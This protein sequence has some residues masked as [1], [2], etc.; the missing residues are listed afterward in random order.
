MVAARFFDNCDQLERRA[1]IEKRIS[2]TSINGLLVHRY[3]RQLV[4]PNGSDA[5]KGIALID[6][7]SCERIAWQRPAEVSCQRKQKRANGKNAA[8]AR[9]HCRDSCAHHRSLVSSAEGVPRSHGGT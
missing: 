5:L 6:G 2:R 7:I 9:V 4:A 8:P 3:A 1:A